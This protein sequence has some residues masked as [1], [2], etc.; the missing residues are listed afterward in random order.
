MTG[1]YVGK[2][3]V[4]RYAVLRLCASGTHRLHQLVMAVL[5]MTLSKAL[6]FFLINGHVILG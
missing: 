6:L 2:R 5:M 4:G 1:E 3:E